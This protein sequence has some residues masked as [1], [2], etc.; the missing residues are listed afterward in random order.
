MPAWCSKWR[1]DGYDDRE[2]VA[3]TDRFSTLDTTFLKGSA[4][5]A[6]AGVAY[7]AEVQP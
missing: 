6:A 3:A 4:A 5:V 2:P 7:W 1:A